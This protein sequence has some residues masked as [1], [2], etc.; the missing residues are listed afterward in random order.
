[1]SDTSSRMNARAVRFGQSAIALSVPVLFIAMML[2]G[3]SG[4]RTTPLGALR[5]VECD[6]HRRCG[7]RRGSSRSSNMYCRRSMKSQNNSRP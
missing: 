6:A 7:I 3:T 5:R 1:M 4:T 2:G